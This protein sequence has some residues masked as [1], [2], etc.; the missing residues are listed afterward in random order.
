MF[1]KIRIGAAK[2]VKLILSLIPR[3]VC[4]LAN[5]NANPTPWNSWT[6]INVLCKFSRF[7]VSWMRLWVSGFRGFQSVTCGPRNF[8]WMTG[9]NQL[10]GWVDCQATARLRPW[11][12]EAHRRVCCEPHA[13]WCCRAK[14]TELVEDARGGYPRKQ[15]RHCGS[16]C[17]TRYVAYQPLERNFELLQYI[18]IF[19]LLFCCKNEQYVKVYGCAA[20]NEHSCQSVFHANGFSKSECY[21]C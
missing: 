9:V 2:N 11:R 3:I 19:I 16:I 10:Q 20:L 4:T 7:S 12:R 15:C 14:N 6:A 1:L 21:F 13:L 17:V 8:S 5:L 18:Y